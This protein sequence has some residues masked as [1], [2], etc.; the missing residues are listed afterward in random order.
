MVSSSGASCALGRLDRM[1]KVGSTLQA[2]KKRIPGA[3]VL[4]LGRARLVAEPFRCAHCAGLMGGRRM[5]DGMSGQ[6][7][8]RILLFLQMGVLAGVPSGFDCPLPHLSHVRRACL[9]AT[10]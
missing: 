1:S 8:T 9:A 3:G 4:L 6:L 2:S 10:N 5:W 7:R